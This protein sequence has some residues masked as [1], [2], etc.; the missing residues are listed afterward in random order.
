MKTYLRLIDFAKPLGGFIAPYLILT[1]L[2]SIFSLANFAMLMPLLDI[3]FGN[4]DSSTIPAHPLTLDDFELST[5]FIKNYGYQEFGRIIE[6]QGPLT[7]LL[8]LCSITISASIFANIFRYMA[9]R[10]A[11]RLK[12]KT[13]ANIRQAMYDK[14]LSLDIGFFN[15][16][17]RGDIV[18]RSTNDI[19]AVEASITQSLT[20]FVRE[21][22]N[23]IVFFWALF[24]MS[25]QLTLF[26][27]AL[28]PVSGGGIS[29]IAKK[30]KKHSKDV[31]SISSSLVSILDETIGGM[32]VIK[33]FN[34]EGFVNGK[35]Q[36][37][38]DKYMNSFTKEANRRELASPFS[39]VMGVTFVA[40]LLYYGGKLVLDESSSAPL[41]AS[42]FIGYIVLFTQVLNPAKAISNTIGVIQRGLAA[43]ERLLE[44]MEVEPAIK[45]SE[46][47]KELTEFKGSIEFKN[48]HFAY[49]DNKVLKGINL[50]IEKGKTVALVGPS[51]GG[52]STIADLIPRFYDV[53]EGEILI[54]GV[55]IKEYSLDSL[56]RV[57][58]VVTQESILF[59]DSIF[60]N[61]AF[62]AN[63]ASK[64]N[65]MQAAKI[66]NA[67]EFIEKS[68]DGYN[69]VIGE[70]GTK[71]SG[72]QRQRLSIARAVFKNPP[73]LILDEA[74]SA[75]DTESEKLVQDAITH[76]MKN[77]TSLVIA[78]RLST[79]QD[80]DEI[81]V[82]KDGGVVERGT[83]NALMQHDDGVYKKLQDL[84]S[85]S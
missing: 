79:I 33:A 53:T 85:I 16:Q 41:E 58:G 24:S 56:R 20:T 25:P 80:A 17:R 45:D 77:R 36:E 29:F 10:M 72:G 8:A 68:E 6:Q 70:R 40:V 51:G 64:D 44:F 82:I 1:T 3:L 73:I 21:P 31:Q 78:H 4:I 59:H 75:L 65:V 35:Y 54:D 67:H 83:H 2:A 71:L 23:L 11:E 63:N 43:G 9:R 19:F 38:N 5:S 32:R 18:S 34:A 7:A 84:Q 57:M 12:G 52:K 13:I 49:G 61:I 76:L 39:E 27:L 62:G 42:Q 37:E 30:L 46:P 48:V 15:N 74:T 26:T 81:I 22:I 28:I 14:V 50:S 55:N 47:L 66:A 69:T 60:N